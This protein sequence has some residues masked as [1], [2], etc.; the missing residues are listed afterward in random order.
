[1]RQTADEAASRIEALVADLPA[2]LRHWAVG[3]ASGDAVPVF[4]RHGP[5]AAEDLWYDIAREQSDTAWAVLP[6]LGA[7]PADRSHAL[8]PVRGGVRGPTI[9]ASPRPPFDGRRPPARRDRRALRGG[10]GGV[11]ASRRPSQLVLDRRRRARLPIEWGEGWPASVS[12]CGSAPVAEL[13]R[14]LFLE[15]WRRAEPIGGSRG[16]VGAA[17]PAD[18]AGRHARRGISPT[19]HQSANGSAARC[20]GDGAVRRLDVVRPGCRLGRGRGAHRALSETSLC[21]D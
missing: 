11:P 9:S 16:A 5:Q 15:L 21:F 18:E 19:R 6:D 8:Q 4:V 10:R 13:G 20:G 2:L 14:S 7:L 1:M 12:V 17:S 3:E